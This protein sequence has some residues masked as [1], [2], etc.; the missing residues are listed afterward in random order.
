MFPDYL[1]L[2]LLTIH[3]DIFVHISSVSLPPIKCYFSVSLQHLNARKAT[4]GSLC[5]PGTNL[6]EN[7]LLISR[8]ENIRMYEYK[9]VRVSQENT[10]EITSSGFGTHEGNAEKR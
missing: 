10:A 4:C 5:G 9:L 6:S 1:I 8:P 7:S 3:F 2:H